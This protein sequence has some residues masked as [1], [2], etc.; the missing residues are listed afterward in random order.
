MALNSDGISKVMA[1][2]LPC[3]IRADGSSA[4]SGRTALVRWRSS[5]ADRLYQ[6]YVNGEYAGLTVDSEQ[7]QLV[8]ALPANEQ[9]PV[10]IEVF[11]VEAGEADT[12][13]GSEQG[14][15]AVSSCLLLQR[16]K[17][18]LTMEAGR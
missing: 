4:A 11:A 6:V 1:F 16:L 14:F 18:I 10:R 15:S 8:V 17:Y 2:E 3:G 5:W 13:F 7:R 9:S 12:D